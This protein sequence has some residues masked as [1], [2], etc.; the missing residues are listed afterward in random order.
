MTTAGSIGLIV[1]LTILFLTGNVLAAFPITGVGGFLIEAEKIDGRDFSLRAKT[2]DTELKKNWGQASVGLGSVTIT[3][4][5]LS[6]SIHLGSAL[7][8]YGISDLDIVIIPGQNANVT[9]NNLTLGTTGLTASYAKFGTL[10]AEE[11]KNARPIDRFSLTANS[12]V[13][14]KAII[15]THSMTASSIRIPGLKVKF[16]L[17]DNDGNIVSG[18]F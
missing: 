18:D 1:I 7:D 12:L 10:K 4:L 2:G 13:L 16:I 5:V 3:G 9:G 17:K 14:D 15:N 11:N 6:K 8:R